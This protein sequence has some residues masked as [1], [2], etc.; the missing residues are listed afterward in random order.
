M[1]SG[2]VVLGLVTVVLAGVVAWRFV[3]DD[4]PGGGAVSEEAAVDAVAVETGLIERRDLRETRVF[5]GSL[6]ATSHFEVVARV[7]GR[8]MS[9][10]ADIG[11]RIGRGELLARLEEVEFVQQLRQAEGE[12]QVAE[13]SIAEAESERLMATRE[14]ER[15]R[16]LRERKISSEAE[17]ETAEAEVRAAEARLRMAE[18]TLAQRAA[19]VAMAELRVSRTR[20]TASWEGEGEDRVVAERLVDEGAYV[21]ADQSLLTLVGLRTLRAVIHVTERD[22]ALIRPGLPAEVRVAAFPGEVFPAR[23]AR[24]APVFDAASRQ[25]RVEIEVFNEEERLVPGMFGRVGLK[26]REAPGAIAVPR[27]SLVRRGGRE[28]VFLVDREEGTA[29]FVPLELGLTDQTFVEVRSPEIS[30]R[31]VTLGQG[32]LTDGARV[33]VVDGAGAG[34]ASAGVNR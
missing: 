13:A 27:D 15:I 24:V 17:L 5:T 20:V 7:P 11:D 33:R 18:G 32:Q 29:R 25:A 8:L 19:A 9:L 23:V 3:V 2:K 30:G 21:T 14:L 4:G 1:K 16:S 28:G 22:Y 6:E 12:R 10:E 31:I 34:T 26:L